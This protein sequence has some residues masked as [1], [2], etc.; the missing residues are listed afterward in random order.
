MPANQAKLI[1]MGLGY[2]E[3]VTHDYIRHGTTTLLA[4]LDVA[5]VTVFAGCKPRHPNQGFL[6]LPADASEM[7]RI[8]IRP[9]PG[10]SSA[11]NAGAGNRQASGNRANKPPCGEILPV[12]LTGVK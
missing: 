1:P 3:G 4:A 5:T 7:C 11:V 12:A 9:I 6:Q 2:V 10:P 8:R